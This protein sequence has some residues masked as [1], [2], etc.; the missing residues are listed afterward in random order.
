MAA[1][2]AWSAREGLLLAFLNPKLALFF[3]ALFSQFVPQ[4]MTLA[5]AATLT[6][7]AGGIDL[8]W[9]SLVALGLSHAGVMTRLQGNP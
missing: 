5:H 7:T 4:Q 9:Y 1:P 3:V 8:L 2:L 6:L